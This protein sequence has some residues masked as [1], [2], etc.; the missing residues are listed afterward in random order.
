[1]MVRFIGKKLSRTILTI[2]A[3][4][5]ALP[6]AVF[7]VYTAGHQASDMIDEMTVFGDELFHTVYGGI[8]YPMSVGDSEAVR[9][10]LLQMSSKM[11][12]VQIY[13]A[14]LNQNVIY[15]TEAE[16]I[17]KR[18]DNS[19]YSQAVWKELVTQPKNGTVLKRSFEERIAGR[20][21]LNMVRLV[22][23]QGKCHGCHGNDQAILGSMV[24]RMGTDRT[25]D[26]IFAHV[27]HNFLIG[28]L[29]I[30]AI[31]AI[32]YL[33]LFLLVTR[34]VKRLAKE[35]EELPEKIEEGEYEARRLI[36]REDEIGCLEKTYYKMRKELFEKN[37]I[38]KKTNEELTAANKELEA[39]AYS[40]S[41][42]LR[43]PLRNID[44]FSKI[45]LEEYGD[46]LEGMGEHYLN[47]VRNGAIKMSQLIDDMLNFSRAGRAELRLEE[48]SMNRM[49]NTVLRDFSEVIKAKDID[50][51]VDE[52]PVVLCDQK[53]MQHVFTNLISNAI[54]YSS[55]VNR[56]HI[57][58]GF[59]E[60]LK[61]FY[62]KD[63]GIGFDMQYHDKIFQV[64]QRLQL[65]EEY[66]GT[67]IGLAIVKRLVERH[68]GRIW[69][70]SEPGSGSVFYIQ[71]PLGGMEAA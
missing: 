22:E 20:R 62:V 1:M 55:E 10:Q 38:I 57:R 41:H 29:G 32:S 30:S 64:F 71:L 50:V 5:L 14:D 43:A 48:I 51:K 42:D 27:R 2:L 46:K 15:T 11:Q 34:P 26:N 31:I 18:I 24:V 23:N 63:K 53:M 8:E 39:F 12:D 7:I 44:G 37:E 49:V 52:L 61:A 54:K 65:P 19:I 16:M 33:L 67:G 35:L 17:G 9:E 40:V 13:I 21:Y 36:T 47:R 4:S 68:Y 60:G 69:A 70:E 59:D 28:I 25:Y 56:P 3:F 58:V 6:L 45:V 66:D